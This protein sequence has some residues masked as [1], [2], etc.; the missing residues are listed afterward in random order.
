MVPPEKLGSPLT[1]IG[2]LIVIVI[3][4]LCSTR[5]TTVI[6]FRFHQMKRFSLVTEQPV[7]NFPIQL[8]PKLTPR[9]NHRT[10]NK[11]VSSSK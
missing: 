2:I 8:I 7:L 9:R 3:A 5:I 11:K 6:G 10:R 4:P 1:K